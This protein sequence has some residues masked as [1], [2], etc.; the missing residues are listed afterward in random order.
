M[1]ITNI[2][3]QL[4]KV[5]TDPPRASPEETKAGRLTEIS[6]LVVRIQTDE[7]VEGIGTSYALQG[8]GRA[9][10][11]CLGEDLAPLLIGEDPLSNEK[12][13]G[14]VN[15]RLATVGRMGLVQQAYSALDLALWDIKGKVADLPLYKLLGGAR[16]SSPIYGSD[17]AWLWMS[18][19]EIITASQKYLD[20]GFIGI[21]MKI[22][23][24]MWTD[25]ERVERVREA[26]GERIWFGVDANQKY[27]C[28]EAMT[29]GYYL[30]DETDIDWIEEPI[31]CEDVNGHSRLAQKLDVPI[32][33]GENL[34]NVDEFVRYLERDAMQV[35]QPDITRVGGITGFLKVASLSHQYGV[36]VAPHLQ[37]E[38]AVHLACGLPHVTLVELMPWT[39][40][41][42]ANPPKIVEGQIVPN[43][44]PGLGITLNEDAV[45][46]YRVQ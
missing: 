23:I 12:I 14:K 38:I 28:V 6:T 46:K 7:N 30:Q 32:A 20:D 27:T 13:A 33:C 8:S 26:L 22:G 17:S 3:A 43:A 36:P 21:K 39:Y 10:L 35:M 18:I 19:E 16:E 44:E 9:M 31:H 40:P 45:T 42:L 24:D 34:W 11:V 41:I 2:E 15:A 5:P 1:Q 29:L 25:A 4:L 37:P